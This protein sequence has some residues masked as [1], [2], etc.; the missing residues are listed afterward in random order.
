MNRKKFEGYKMTYR[1]NASHTI[2][3]MDKV[4]A[5]TFWVKLYIK[6]DTLE[7]VEF[8]NYEKEITDYFEGYRRKCINEFEA[9]KDSGASLEN[10]CRVFFEDIKKVFE[11][12]EEFSLVKLELGDSPINSVSCA[13]EVIAGEAGIFIDSQLFERYR[14]KYMS[15]G[16][17]MSDE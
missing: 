16:K 13:T 5:H 9:F 10:M 2:S 15:I 6:K 4:H 3:T 1:F 14:G 17:E 8:I 7:F 11:G 12:I